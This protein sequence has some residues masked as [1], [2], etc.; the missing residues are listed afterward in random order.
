MFSMTNYVTKALHKFQHPTLRRSQYAP[1]QWTRPNDGATKKL[2][3]PLDTLLKIPEERKRRIQ[4]I[5]VTFLYYDRA[6]GYTR[7][8]EA[9]NTRLTRQ[10][11]LQVAD[12][13]VY[14]L[15]QPHASRDNQE[16]V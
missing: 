14:K 7:Y 10:R 3:T 15:R 8:S 13:G 5:V 2:A 16:P 12:T 9:T 1:Y 6:M 11:I 4:K